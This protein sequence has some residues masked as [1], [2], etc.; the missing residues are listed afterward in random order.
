VTLVA[1]SGQVWR[2]PNELQPALLDPRSAATPAGGALASQG[3]ALRV[4]ETVPAASPGA[5]RGSVRLTSFGAGPA[6]QAGA[7]FVAAWDAARLPPPLGSG[8]PV[9]LR[10]FPSAAVAAALGGS[11]PFRLGDLPPGRYVVAALLDPLGQVQPQLDFASG[12]PRGGQLAFYS[13]GG[14]GPLPVTVGASDVPL[15][16]IV[17]DR[18]A[19]RAVPSERPAF[20]VD[21][22]GSQASISAR[23]APG[24]AGSSA[25]LNLL[26]AAPDGLPY[27]AAGP[28]AFHPTPALDPLGNPRR[29]ALGAGC[30]GTLNQPWISTQ[31]VVAPL[32]TSQ[33]I[34]PAVAVDACQFCAALTGTADC[35]A[36]LLAPPLGPAPFAGPVQVRISNE[37]VD[38]GSGLPTV[39]PLP[40]GRYSV[41]LVEQT[42]QIWTLP[43]D[44]L[45]V[46]GASG[47]QQGF[48]FQVQ[49]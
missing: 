12:L 19:T 22:A 40:P 34:G 16:E 45:R 31:A 8:T 17:L 46:D 21:P 28:P 14:A 15:P 11:L 9:A 27:V 30:L 41:T 39:A 37:A 38:L 26:P 10:R 13:G 43:N 29:A 36:G 44:L 2:L 48:V 35:S 33:P 49:P 25:L 6:G 5:I 32:D 42:G 18:T 3:V 4:A 23:A 7:L 47:L 20:R 1:R 24:A